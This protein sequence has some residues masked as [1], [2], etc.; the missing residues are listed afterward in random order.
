MVRCLLR[1]LRAAVL[2]CRIAAELTQFSIT[3]LSRHTR[4]LDLNHWGLSSMSQPNICCSI[5]WSANVLCCLLLEL[6]VLMA[7]VVLGIAA[8]VVPYTDILGCSISRFSIALTSVVLSRHWDRDMK[9]GGGV[10]SQ[11]PSIGVRHGVIDWGDTE[12]SDD[13]GVM[14][15]WHLYWESSQS[16]V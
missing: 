15:S 16:P 12:P 7:W 1:I 8:V 10:T 6:T 9:H 5:G 3:L 13:F 2:L 14:L 4:R 11:L